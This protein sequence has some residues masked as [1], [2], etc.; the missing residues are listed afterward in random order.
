M[1]GAGAMVDK[2]GFCFVGFALFELSLESAGSWIS[3]LLDVSLFWVF[4]REEVVSFGGRSSFLVKIS[5]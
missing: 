2:S 3:A 5:K 1:M 4:W